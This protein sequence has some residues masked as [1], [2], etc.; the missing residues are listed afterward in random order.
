MISPGPW[1]RVALR[2]FAWAN[3]PAVVKTACGLVGDSTGPVRAPL[4]P[5]VEPPNR[6]LASLPDRTAAT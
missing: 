6:E 1:R 4:L 5:L 3:Y 2:R